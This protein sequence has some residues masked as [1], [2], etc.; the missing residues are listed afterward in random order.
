[1]LFA[2]DEQG[3]VTIDW[4]TLTAVIVALGIAVIYSVIG[5]SAGHIMDEFDVL[6]SEIEA[7][8]EIVST[9]AQDININQ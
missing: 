3:A 6:N 4:V 9:A 7:L 1:M 8:G 2:N 5:N